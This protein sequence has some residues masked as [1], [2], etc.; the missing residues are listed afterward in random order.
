MVTDKNAGMISSVNG[1][2]N[3]D[4]GFAFMIGLITV[5]GVASIAAF[6]MVIVRMIIEIEKKEKKTRQELDWESPFP[7]KDG[8]V[9]VVLDDVIEA[10]KRNPATARAKV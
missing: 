3:M 8:Y 2:K 6:V 10:V 1:E 4:I 7:E 5:G 9:E